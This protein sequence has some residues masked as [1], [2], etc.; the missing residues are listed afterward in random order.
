MKMK[1]HCILSAGR[2]TSLNKRFSF[3]ASE[4]VASDSS[5]TAGYHT[6]KWTGREKFLHCCA[7]QPPQD[8]TGLCV[9][10]CVRV[11][12]FKCISHEYNWMFSISYSLSLSLSDV[13]SSRK[14]SDDSSLCASVLHMLQNGL[15]P[16]SCYTSAK[17]D[18]FSC[19]I[20]WQMWCSTC[21]CH[22]LSFCLQGSKCP[23]CMCHITDTRLGWT[24]TTGKLQWLGNNPK[25]PTICMDRLNCK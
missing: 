22:P 6:F 12:Y 13:F 1:F 5:Y 9:C 3:H 14:V 15:L 2:C 18:F 19:Y 21:T 8:F 24:K 23:V 17:A 7:V 16:L 4:G 10:A 11:S 20:H 25:P